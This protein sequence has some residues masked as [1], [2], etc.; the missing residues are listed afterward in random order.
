MS[1]TLTWLLLV[2]QTALSTLLLGGVG[3]GL[4]FESEGRHGRALHTLA[5]VFS[6]GAVVVA[7]L[8]LVLSLVWIAWR[9][10]GGLRQGPFVAV[11]LLACLLALPAF[12]GLM[13]ASENANASARARLEAE[14]IAA[15]RASLASGSDAAACPLIALDPASTEPEMVRCLDK[16]EAL[17]PAARSAELAPF[18]DRGFKSH[19]TPEQRPVFAPSQQARFVRLFFEA[20]LADPRVLEAWESRYTVIDGLREVFLQG[21]SDAA[22]REAAV[23]LPAFRERAKSLT[24]PE[25]V[26]SVA[27]G[28][29]E[30]DRYAAR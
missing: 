24:D 10:A 30:L 26:S 25:A 22:K 19:F 11:P 21:W 6:G 13:G 2:F 29:D 27:S 23:L 4:A 28:L 20:Q 14:A 17:A 7:L 8:P 15:L 1:S 16:L 3:V 9:L 12:L 5:T 18:I